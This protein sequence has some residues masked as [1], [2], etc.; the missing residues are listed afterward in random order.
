MNKYILKNKLCF[1]L[2]GT[3]FMVFLSGCGG[4]DT[5]SVKAI[6]KTI[7][8]KADYNTA[9]VEKG[10]MEPTITL[11]LT[12][13]VVST[14][15][16][17]VEQENLEVDEILVNAGEQVKKGQVLVTFKAEDIRKAIEKYRDAVEKNQLLLDH[18]TRLANVDKKADYTIEI[19]K[20][21]DDVTLSKLFLEE[22]IQ[23]LNEC[24][25]IASEDGTVSYISNVLL[26]GFVAPSTCMVTEICGEGTYYVETS[27]D[28]NFQIGDVYTAQNE[29]MD[30][31]LKLIS[32]QNVEASETEETSA[33]T[34]LRKLIFQPSS[35]FLGSSE[36]K[37]LTL[38][39]KKASLKNVVYVT[40]KAIHN[41]DGKTFVYIISENGFLDAHYVETG[42]QVGDLVEIKK[43]LAGGEEVAL[44]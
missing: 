39:I 23:K 28:Y 17:T 31:E 2:T 21:T 9:M 41:K 38:T 12:P 35:S 16:Y 4:H 8:Q 40:N 11:K 5:N 14:I 7:Y 13:E 6:E 25:I 24:S 42:E 3:L 30:C 32:I 18:Y 29:S 33:D 15:D 27:D 37:A 20:L 43:G 34:S 44:K 26:S 10:D 36:P 1:L 22:E 19:E